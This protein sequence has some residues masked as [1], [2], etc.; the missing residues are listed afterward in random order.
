MDCDGIIMRILYAEDET[1]LN[2]IVTKALEAE[3]FVVDS[4]FDGEEA[5]H[6]MNSGLRCRSYLCRRSMHRLMKCKM[7]SMWN[8]LKW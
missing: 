3:R 4:C 7:R 2:G 1:D 8:P 6:R 5:M